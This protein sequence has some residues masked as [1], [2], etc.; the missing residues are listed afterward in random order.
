MFSGVYDDKMTL[1]TATNKLAHLPHIFSMI[2]FSLLAL[3]TIKETITT[4][5]HETDFV[6]K[7]I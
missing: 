4:P 1:I 3:A 5:P 7:T 2:L 6:L